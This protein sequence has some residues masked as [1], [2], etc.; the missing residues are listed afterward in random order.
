MQARPSHYISDHIILQSAFLTN[1]REYAYFQVNAKKYNTFFLLRIQN[2]I[3]EMP[4]FTCLASYRWRVHVSLSAAIWSLLLLT[5]SVTGT[6]GG[7][8][9]DQEAHLGLTPGPDA[10]LF[11][12]PGEERQWAVPEIEIIEPSSTWEH[13]FCGSSAITRFL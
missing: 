8:L 5:D 7:A 13:S 10:K 2:S 3:A 6:E 1:Y 9:A 4:Q 12:P 11:I